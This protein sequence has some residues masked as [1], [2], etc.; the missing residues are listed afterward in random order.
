MTVTEDKHRIEKTSKRVDYWR[1]SHYLVLD[2]TVQVK[3]WWAQL[4]SWAVESHWVRER[5]SWVL[6]NMPWWSSQSKIMLFVYHIER[7]NKSA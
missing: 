2:G 5:T 1:K 7:K 6:R 3:D 4:G